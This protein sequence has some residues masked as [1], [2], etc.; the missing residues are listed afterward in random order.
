MPVGRSQVS[1]QSEESREVLCLSQWNP[2]VVNNGHECL[3]ALVY[4]PSERLPMPNPSDPLRVV[5]DPRLAQRNLTLEQVAPGNFMGLNFIF[6]NP[7]GDSETRAGLRLKRVSLAEM[8]H[9]EPP[10]GWPREELSGTVHAGLAQGER[11]EGPGAER[12]ASNASWDGP[13]PAE[14]PSALELVLA[15][16]EQWAVT[17]VLAMPEESTEG[18]GAAFVVEQDD[19]DEVLGGCGIVVVAS[20]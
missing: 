16:N 15:P 13:H 9:A 3:I 12:P 4:S 6:R 7:F 11:F 10:E 18:Q 2:I 8:I 1:L 17:A 14:L 19:G 5:E 20:V